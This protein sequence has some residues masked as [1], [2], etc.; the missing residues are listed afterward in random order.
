MPVTA[1]SNNLPNVNAADIGGATSAG[2]AGYAG[3]DWSNIA[4]P[5][6]SVDLINTTIAGT[7]NPTSANVTEW[8]GVPV[9]ATAAGIPDVNVL[10]I[11]NTTAQI[12]GNTGGVLIAGNNAQT[13]FTSGVVVTDGGLTINNNSGIGMNVSGSTLGIN[14]QGGIQ[15]GVLIQGGSSG[16]ALTLEA[17]VG[18]SGAGLSATGAESGPGIFATGGPGNSDG[19][20]T[21]HGIVASGNGGDGCGAIFTGVGSGAGLEVQGGSSGSGLL[22]SGGTNSSGVRIIG[23]STASMHIY[24]WR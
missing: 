1:D 20:L 15:D 24:T 18:S 14:I 12:P 3:I 7:D 10:N 5:T 21:S 16:N 13:V 22:A 4:N 11:A 2:D 8:L 19:N 23:D 6:Q 9:T 17:G